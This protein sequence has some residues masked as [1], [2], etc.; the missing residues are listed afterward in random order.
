[1]I[2]KFSEKTGRLLKNLNTSKTILIV[3]IIG[4]VLR[5]G[6]VFLF[7]DM[8]E[9]RLMD[10]FK[11][12]KVAIH[13]MQGRGFCEYIRKP[14]AF[15]P[16]L[17]PVFLAG[18]FSVFGINSVIVKIIQAFLGV[19]I[20]PM[21]FLMGK[22]LFNKETGLIA[23]G[24]LAVYPDLIVISA[25]LY[26]ETLY[27]FFSM[28]AFYFLIKGFKQEFGFLLWIMSGFFL[29]LG[30]LTR[31]ILIL[32]PV[33]IL[34]LTI[35]FKG[36]RHLIKKVAIMA[37]VC[38]AVITPWIIRNYIQFHEFIPIARGV[39]AG[40][41]VGSNVEKKGEYMYSE[42]RNLANKEAGNFDTLIE[43][44]N[45]L[46]GKAIERIVH[47]PVTYVSISGKKFFQFFFKFY[48]SVPRGQP[49]A[50]DFKVLI[51]LAAS[52][53]FLLLFTITGVFYAIKN[54]ERLIVVYSVI[55]YSGLVHSM[56]IVVP[57]YRI[58]L[59]PFFVILAAYGIFSLINIKNSTD[60][61]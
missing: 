29:G 34:S 56:T 28:I 27:L 11:Y 10:S 57:R 41:W 18:V 6:F 49:R 61:R 3:V 33:F 31:H 52:Y 16:P 42:T 24:I 48:K 15:A 55:L 12:K 5:I 47:D 9:G 21:I 60:N 35:I 54:K 44:D 22:T 17:Y 8:G 59:Y 25:Y 38:Y 4:L 13:L 1:M 43:R 7:P 45:K 32:F 51:V 58:P 53:A 50:S 2:K 36:Y 14:S 23:A 20:I 19:S 26:T 37:L 39:R 46:F 40:L 30:L